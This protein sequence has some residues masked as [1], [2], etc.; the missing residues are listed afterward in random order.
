MDIFSTND[1]R[2]VL[3][4]QASQLKRG[5]GLE[6]NFGTIAKKCH[7]Q[8]SY[9]SKVFKE[10]SHLSGDQLFLLVE[11]L[12]FNGDEIEFIEL[13]FKYQRS[14]L[15]HRRRRL[16]ESIRAFREK[17]LRTEDHL[18]ADIINSKSSLSEQYF[19]S[20][21]LQLIHLLLGIKS[22]K[23][24]QSL[25]L[26]L[27][28]ISSQQYEVFLARLEAMNLIKRNGPKLSI[29]KNHFFLSKDSSITHAYHSLMKTNAF[30]RI[31]GLTKNQKYALSVLFNGTQENFDSI[32]NKFLNVLKE[33]ERE[34]TT[35]S[36]PTEVY[37][38]S[39][40][41]FPWT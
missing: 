24:D 3:H 30:S 11:Y 7:I 5:R 25:I 38:L 12:E 27:L 41:L 22:F 21:Q 18:S 1:Y 36:N 20:P 34:V 16:K 39:I 28:N 32:R 10:E 15:P 4:R 2:K 40:D 14:S 31:D 6:F 9:L 35:T 33:I 13:L 8:S 29:V 19:L 23:E 37:Q 17:K 26:N